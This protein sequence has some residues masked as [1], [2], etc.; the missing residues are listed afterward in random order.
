MDSKNSKATENI[1]RLIENKGVQFRDFDLTGYEKRSGE[2]GEPDKLIITGKPV[3]FDD[4]TFLYRDLD[5][6]RIYEKIDR[7]AF[8]EADMSDV[9]FNMNHGGRVYA[10]T[11]NN[12]LQLNV[13][14]DGVYMESELW[15]DDPGHLALYRDIKRGNIDRM[16]FAF[17]VR[18]VR[19][20]D[21]DEELTSTRTIMK[22]DRLF[23]VSAV[24]IPAYDATE[25]SAR[26]ACEPERQ[27]RR[28][29][30]MRAESLKREQERRRRIALKLK[31]E[32]EKSI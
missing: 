24:D 20:E 10:R 1:K 5:G 31:L 25:I 30:S 15:P 26:S 29:E 7:H 16:S 14:D 21:D 17:T 28:A 23:D 8:D 6:Y 4:P 11:R 12:S 2:N 9:I 13:K 19:W 3:V 18:T 32:K 27:A 22:I